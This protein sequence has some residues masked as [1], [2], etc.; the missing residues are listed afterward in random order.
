VAQT[1]RCPSCDGSLDYDGFSTIIRC[2]FCNSSVIVPESLRGLPGSAGVTA[3]MD[4]SQAT[5]LAEIVQLAK[6]P[7]KKIQAIKLYRETFDVGLAEAKEAVELLAAGKSVAITH[8]ATETTTSVDQGVVLVQIQELLRNGLKIEAIKRYREVYNVGLKEAKD[9]VDAIEA[10]HSDTLP[11]ISGEIDDMVDEA[12]NM[13]RIAEFMREG[14]KIEAIKLYRET[15]DVGLGDAK[16]AVEQIAQGQPVIMTRRKQIKTVQT[17]AKAGR[18]PAQEGGRGCG[19]LLVLLFSLPFVIPILAI[20]L[21]PGGP[22]YPYWARINPFAPARL[23][24]AFGEEGL[25]EGAFYDIRNIASDGD[26]NI[27]VA[28]YGSGRLQRFNSNGDF[29]SLWLLGENNY[30][31]SLEVSSEGTVYVINSQGVHQY[32]ADGTLVGAVGSGNEYYDDL[33]VVPGGGLVLVEDNRLVR[34][35]G[36]ENV[37][38][39]ATTETLA[40]NASFDRVA[41]DGLGNVYVL[42][43]TSDFQGSNDVVFIFT[44]DGQFTGQFGNSGEDKGQ[45]DGPQDIAADQYGRVY[46]SQWSYVQVFDSSG[47]YLHRI[48][49]NG[50]PFGISVNDRDELFIASNEEKVFKY[51]IKPPAGG[52]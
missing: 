11:P 18:V 31:S 52:E 33:A 39:T 47:R 40:N 35:N 23:A 48:G 15:F 21:P 37:V 32:T 22:L 7:N 44:A 43:Q 2:S 19:I 9:A 30:I 8:V 50:Y 5:A 17:K 3:G 36:Q 26:G 1:F 45:L 25:G 6:Q 42:G 24:L 14:K 49:V 4:L 16:E 29:Q 34:L 10:G 13:A 28:D 41:V 38:W 46:I 51:L 20:T 12:T 27:Y